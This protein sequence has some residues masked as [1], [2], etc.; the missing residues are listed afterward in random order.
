M[1]EDRVPPPLREVLGGW[2][3][4]DEGVSYE[5]HLCRR[6]GTLLGLQKVMRQ[7]P[8][9]KVVTLRAFN[10]FFRTFPVSLSSLCSRSSKKITLLRMLQT[11]LN[12]P[13]VKRFYDCLG[14]AGEGEHVALFVRMDGF[15]DGLA[16]HNMFDLRRQATQVVIRPPKATPLCVEKF[17]QFIRYAVRRT[18]WEYNPED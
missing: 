18:G 12:Q 13:P 6:L 5:S 14:E 4:E 1:S 17:D 10:R 8:G 11:P 9:G 16:F 7:A 3:R 2:N 15:A